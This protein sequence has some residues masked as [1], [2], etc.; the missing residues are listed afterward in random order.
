VATAFT[1]AA[2]MPVEALTPLA[3]PVD[4]AMTP[5]AAGTPRRVPAHVRRGV[6]RD[7]RRAGR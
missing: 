3:R 4:S 6:V 1:T 5:S 2:G 7:D